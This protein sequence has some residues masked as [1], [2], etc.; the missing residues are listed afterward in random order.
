MNFGKAALAVV[1]MLAGVAQAAADEASVH[2]FSG[3]YAGVSAT[4]LKG[5][6]S[7]GSARVDF[8]EGALGGGFIGYNHRAGDF[9]LGAEA[10]VQTGR[11][12]VF[13]ET[14]SITYVA[15]LRA[16]LGRVYGDTFVYVAGGASALH[17]SGAI[18]GAR[19]PLANLGAGVEVP[20]SEEMFLGADYTLRV[21]RSRVFNTR[22]T[23]GYHNAQARIGYRF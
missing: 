14:V 1:A 9:V 8:G 21:T 17:T 3:P 20:L 22:V 12:S 16:R 10:A 2:G 6:L 18:R 13:G 15:D 19:V 4:A 11:A 5:F 23:A 7:A